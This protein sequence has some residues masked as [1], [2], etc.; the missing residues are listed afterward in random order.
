M[1]ARGPSGM[2]CIGHL[3]L[4]ACLAWGI[5]VFAWAETTAAADPN[6]S[7]ADLERLVEQIEDPSQRAHLIKTLRALITAAKQAE[8]AAAPSPSAPLAE[9]SRGLLLAFDRLTEHISAFGHT[10]GRGLADL[11]VVLTA[12]PAYVSKPQTIRRLVD[13]GIIVGTLVLLGIGLQRLSTRLLAKLRARPP[14]LTSWPFWRKL[15]SALLIVGLRVAPPLVLLIASGILL[16]AFPVGAPLAGLVALAVLALIAYQLAR[17]IVLVLLKPDE[18]AT[19]LLPLGDVAARWAWTWSMR[20]LTLA[21]VYYVVTRGLALVGVAAEVYAVVRGTLVSAFAVAVSV[22]VIRVAR[23]Q[24]P[25]AMGVPEEARRLRSTLIATARGVW[26]IIALAYVWCAAFFALA[27]FQEG[28]TYMV[29]ASLQMVLVICLVMLLLWASNVAFAKAV[30]LHG[31][32]AQYLPGL[33]V[34]ALRYIKAAWWG[35]WLLIMLIGVL[36]ILQVWG[37]GV[38]WFF[39]S[40]LGSEIL[41]RVIILVFTVAIV[42]LVVDASTFISQRLIEPRPDGG[43][44]SKK[45]KTLIPL[46]GKTVRYAALFVGA[47][48]AL[49]QIGVNVTPIL[50]GVGILGLAVGFGAQTL[51]KD[52][53]NGL[54]ILFEDSIAVGDVVVVKGTG[55]LV[56]AVNLRTIRLRDLQGSVH[57]IPNSQVETITNMTKDFSYYL[58]DVGVAYREDTDEVIA[59]LREIDAGMRQDPAYAAD[60]LEPIE[61]LGVDRFTDSAVIVR[62]RLKTKPIRQWNVGREFNR[63]MKKLFDARGIEIPFPHRT[64][65]WGEPKRGEAAA[66]HLD[67]RNWERLA[68]STDQRNRQSVAS[69]SVEAEKR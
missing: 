24:R 31:R 44:A 18:P 68:P 19:R 13:L 21:V 27:S 25:P 37:V 52:I 2:K 12:L 4:G 60:M 9:Q 41:T 69:H 14:S 48:V 42:A 20:L 49:H 28:V 63:R 8:P 56:E 26:P 30:A 34:R 51:V 10:L 67:I 59:I 17:A 61:I 3:L 22:L 53:I 45:R 58:L 39:T 65:Y 36:I 33:E 7:V 50:A 5:S 57:V 64:L 62:A 32:A 23:R 40:P 46:L 29:G 6:V 38:S 54:F 16:G 47:M 55:G 11:P 15:W 66:M 35:V 1:V 43:E